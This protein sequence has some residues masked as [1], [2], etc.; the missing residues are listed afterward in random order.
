MQALDAAAALQETTTLS[1]MTFSLDSPL[2][3]DVTT[4][5]EPPDVLDRISDNGVEL[6]IGQINSVVA[7]HR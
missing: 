5:P 6:R 4:I 7:G 2:F 1:D 3:S